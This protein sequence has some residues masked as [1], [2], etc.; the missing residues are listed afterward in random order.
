MG[1]GTVLRIVK[2]LMSNYNLKV[3][4]AFLRGQHFYMLLDLQTFKYNIKF[5]EIYEQN[6]GMYLN[7]KFF[8][9]K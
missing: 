5:K 3:V 1:M 8:I 2:G 9:P 4:E 6:V 7:N